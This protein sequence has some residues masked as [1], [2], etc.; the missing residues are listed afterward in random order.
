M[1]NL[2]G[3]SL[4]HVTVYDSWRKIGSYCK[5]HDMY[6]A[7]KEYTSHGPFGD[8][9]EEHWEDEEFFTLECPEELLQPL[10]PLHKTGTA[11]VF[12]HEYLD[13]FPGLGKILKKH[14]FV[15]VKSPMKTGKTCWFT[16]EIKTRKPKRV[17]IIS[18]RIQLSSSLKGGFK[19]LGFVSYLDTNDIASHDRVIIQY[20]SLW[21]LVGVK[22]FDLII[23]DEYQSL[24][25]NVHA[26]TNG[27]F[28]TTNAGVFEAF[29]RT[30]GRFIACDADLTNRGLETL[31]LMIGETLE[32]GLSQI[33][34]VHNTFLPATREHW[35]YDSLVQLEGV[36]VDVVKAGK[37]IVVCLG[38][39]EYG[40]YLHDKLT[41]LMDDEEENPGINRNHNNDKH[42]IL[43]YSSERGS[44]ADFEN[45]NDAWR[46]AK[47]I[48]YTPKVTVGADYTVADVDEIFLCCKGTSALATTM[49]QMVG[50]VRNPK[51]SVIHTHVD[52]HRR[53]GKTLETDP[54]VLYQGI[55]AGA[56]TLRETEKAILRLNPLSVGPGN[57]IQWGAIKPWI[58]TNLAHAMAA[59]NACLNDYL[60]VLKAL[61]GSRWY[62]FM[63]VKPACDKDAVSAHRADVNIASYDHVIV[64]HDT[65][66]VYDM[67]ATFD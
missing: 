37:K 58:A 56:Q 10:H 14:K 18:T 52:Y 43:Y 23:L 16:K 17:L 22:G 64:Q 48:M 41:K 63:D 42:G 24:L 55:L 46:K 54:K 26:S 20:E 31:A 25:D 61:G 39:K 19:D 32:H 1:E 2:N 40:D 36:I 49:M 33:H 44:M 57:E 53:G 11:D 34:L 21:K 7:F 15:V 38:S 65:G 27:V 47:V 9:L 30:A 50:R 62:T 51:S 59:K 8:K 28:A 6:D 4:S 60:G 13:R 5:E 35:L 3:V 45:I 12:D 67:V 66:G 29:V